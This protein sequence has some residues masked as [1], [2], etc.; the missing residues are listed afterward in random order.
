M[1]LFIDYLVDELTDSLLGMLQA[2]W[3][4]ALSKLRSTYHKLDIGF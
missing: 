2:I 1:M 4:I 3:L